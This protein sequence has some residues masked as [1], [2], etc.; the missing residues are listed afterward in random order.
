MAKKKKKPE[1]A[2][3]PV[4]QLPGQGRPYYDPE[5]KQFVAPDH[6]YMAKTPREEHLNELRGALAVPPRPR[7]PQYRPE[8]VLARML[9]GQMAPDI[10][11]FPARTRPNPGYRLPDLGYSPADVMGTLYDQSKDWRNAPPELPLPPRT[12]DQA[13]PPPAIGDLAIGPIR[14]P[15]PRE[16]DPRLNQGTRVPTPKEIHDWDMLLLRN[17][18][19]GNAG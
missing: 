3:E 11:T 6:D 13:G 16:R 18:S 17:P 7:A 19:I 14:W 5:T 9:A 12:D 4:P 1:P 15:T 10:P 8:D 2:P